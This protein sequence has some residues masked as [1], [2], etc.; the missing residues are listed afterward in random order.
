MV[1]FL[2]L[3]DGIICT[4][5]LVISP[6]QLQSMVVNKQVYKSNILKLRYF[7]NVDWLCKFCPNGTDR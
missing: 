1:L 2:A 7:S 4:A 5:W 6:Y 3:V